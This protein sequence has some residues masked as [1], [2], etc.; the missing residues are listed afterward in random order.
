MQSC[1][2]EIF[3]YFGI[4]LVH[5]P[6]T[7]KLSLCSIPVAMM[8]AIFGGQLAAGDRINHLDAGHHLHREGQVS[9]PAGCEA[10]LV[11]EVEVGGRSISYTSDRTHVVVHLAQH[12]RL[13]TSSEIEKEHIRA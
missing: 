11:L 4:P 5:P 6:K 10:F 7:T 8:I 3:K 2:M 12:V 1:S 9:F 13:D